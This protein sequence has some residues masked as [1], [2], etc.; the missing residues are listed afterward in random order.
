MIQ[1][2]NTFIILC[3]NILLFNSCTSQPK[4]VTSMKNRKAVFAGKFYEENPVKLKQELA[5]LFKQ[6]KPHQ[7]LLPIA[8]ISPHAGYVFSGKTAAS[9]F[10][11]ID[12]TQK[13]D[14]VFILAP[15]HHVLERGA[16]LYTK[17]NYETPLGEVTVN[18]A[19]CKELIKKFPTLFCENDTAQ[20]NEHSL[21][22]QLPFLQYKLG[23]KF[24][25]V[26][27]VVMT[28]NAD[29][30]KQIAT[31]L[32]PYFNAR[33]LFVFSS[34]LSHYPTFED[35]NRVDS[36]T[37]HAILSGNPDTLKQLTSDKNLQSVKNLYT[38]LC[39]KSPVLVLM[40][41]TQSSPEYSYH[42]IDYSNSAQ[43]EYG[44][45]ERVVGYGSI[46][47]T[48]ENNE[49]VLFTEKEK[50]LML[51]IARDAIVNHLQ[52]NPS[53]IL[54]IPENSLLNQPMGAFVS[55]YKKGALR[56]CIGTFHADEA[57]YKTIQEMAIA[58]AMHDHRFEPVEWEEMEEISIEISVLTPLKKI[59]NI[60]EIVLGKHGI[61]I[62]KGGRSGTFLPQVA[63]KTHWTLEDFLGH[64]AG[65]KAGI[66]WNGWKDAD[67][68][69][70]EAI[71]F[72]EE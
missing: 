43:S 22:V 53:P 5:Q 36:E 10:N 69:T 1:Y 4:T 68:Y 63:D 25:L 65:D 61:Y 45:K 9:S 66:G 33:N 21:E 16:S 17:G 52:S 48:H 32:L 72:G 8:I 26:P 44:D 54:N 30:C 42:L 47:V 6:A 58:S 71:V 28:D 23:N 38:R 50:L 27:M 20:E 24:Q 11:Q 12:T 55:L 41:L 40:Y 64:C 29:E 59:N 34:D 60:H 70:Y 46:A 57:L 3:V 19:L 62:K 14:N 35:A 13:Y 67:I 49:A 18:I 39:G 37:I 56:G 51:K 31:A 7:G 15:S 2:K